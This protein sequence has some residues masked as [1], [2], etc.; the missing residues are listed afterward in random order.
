MTKKKT[1]A[2]GTYTPLSRPLFIYVNKASMAKPQVKAFVEFALGEKGKDAVKEAH[3]VLLGDDVMTQIK[4]HVA[5]GTAGTMM[6]DFKP[7]MKLT[8]VYTKK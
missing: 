5:A 1:I 8:D 2:D 7:G 6:K 4:A 3:F